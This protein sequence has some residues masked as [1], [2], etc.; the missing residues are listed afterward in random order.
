MH[1]RSALRLAIPFAIRDRLDL[2][3][4]YGNEGAEAEEARKACAGLKGLVGL[5]PS[6]FEPSQLEIARLALLW[7][8]QYLD[9]YIDAIGTT[10]KQ[11]LKIS[12]RQR[13]QIR[14]ARFKH[15]GKTGLEVMCENA[16]LVDA[17]AYMLARIK[18]G[19]DLKGIQH[20]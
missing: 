11:E 20:A 2:A 10:D 3:Q 15:F 12:I 17:Q 16:V 19:R 9:G 14:S 13:H 18:A 5:K 4:A 6:K 7:G 1:L 8:E